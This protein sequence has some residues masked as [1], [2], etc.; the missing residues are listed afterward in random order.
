[1]SYDAGTRRPPKSDGAFRSGPVPSLRCFGHEEG[2]WL[3]VKYAVFFLGLSAVMGIALA[4]TAER[5]TS[6]WLG[7]AIALVFATAAII[8]WRKAPP[9]KE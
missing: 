7:L 3:V 6:R 1:M 4:L 2:W 9:P 8:A 5:P